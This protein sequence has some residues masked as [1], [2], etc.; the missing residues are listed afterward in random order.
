M[1]YPILPDKFESRLFKYFS[2]R[3]LLLILGV[4]GLVQVSERV[5]FQEFANVLRALNQG[6][7]VR[8]LQDE[9]R[10]KATQ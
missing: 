3:D 7:L 10:Q 6:D 1:S 8:K 2:M 5:G 9:A 4:Y